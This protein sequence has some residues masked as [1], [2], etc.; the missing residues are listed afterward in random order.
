[1]ANAKHQSPTRNCLFQPTP[2]GTCNSPTNERCM[3]VRLP[4]VQY[5]AKLGIAL[6]SNRCGSA[7]PRARL[8]VAGLFVSAFVPAVANRL[9]H[10]IAAHQDRLTRL[11]TLL[12]GASVL[13]SLSCDDLAVHSGE[14]AIAWIYAWGLYARTLTCTAF[15]RAPCSGNSLTAQCIENVFCKA[16]INLSRNSS[17]YRLPCRTI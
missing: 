14:A 11:C 1:M 9:C 2:A 10:L 7:C 3:T 12:Y 5:K 16:S 8:F 6:P 15:K 17:I 4:W 13:G